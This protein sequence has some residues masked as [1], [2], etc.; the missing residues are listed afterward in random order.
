MTLNRNLRYVVFRYSH[1]SPH[2]GY[3]RVA[4]YGEKLFNSETIRIEKPLPRSIIRERML[5]KIAEGT[6]GYDRTSMAMELK[7]G[8]RM[9]SEHGAIFH[10][11]YGET[12]YHYTG[13]LNCKRNN[14]VVATFHLPPAGIRKA[15][16]ID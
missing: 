1:H 4:E 13:L 15:V 9:L 8:L 7:T 5:W 12:T 6:P 11:L 14:R 2:S 3:S 16:H 10:F